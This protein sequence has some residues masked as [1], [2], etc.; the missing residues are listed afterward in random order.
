MRSFFPFP[1]HVKSAG[2]ERAALGPLR[3]AGF[4][5]AVVGSVG[6]GNVLFHAVVG[7]VGKLCTTQRKAD[8]GGHCKR[9]FFR[10]T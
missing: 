5:V 8:D 2:A 10:G 4:L 9:F 7:E 1:R 3:A 6:H